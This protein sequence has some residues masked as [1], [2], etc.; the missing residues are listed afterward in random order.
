M[1]FFKFEF[2]M[3]TDKKYVKYDNYV[4]ISM[5]KNLRKK[6]QD[7]TS[8]NLYCLEALSTEVK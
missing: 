7:L 3:E 5:C 6:K 8:L 4:N 2:K 1:S